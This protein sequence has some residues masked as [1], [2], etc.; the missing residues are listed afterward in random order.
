MPQ[1]WIETLFGPM[2]AVIRDGRLIGLS[3]EREETCT[4]MSFWSAEDRETFGKLALWLKTYAEGRFVE[5][6]AVE[7][8]CSEFEARVYKALMTIP[9]GQTKS[10]GDIAA[11]LQEENDLAGLNKRVS[12][13]AVGRAL[14][15][16]P[17]LLIIPCHRVIRGDGSLG[18][19]AGG[20]DKKLALLHHEAFQRRKADTLF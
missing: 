15:R 2:K 10:Y 13:R 7:L 16:N 9:P 6:P 4:L 12:A 11:I 20:T 19:Y 5:Q 14:G 17:I 3:F 18:G 1:A 8:S